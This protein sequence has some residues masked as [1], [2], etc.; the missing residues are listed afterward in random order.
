MAIDGAV[1]LDLPSWYTAPAR[2]DYVEITK[3]PYQ[4]Q[5]FFCLPVQAKVT[6]KLDVKEG[7]GADGATLNHQGIRP[8]R[9]TL[10]LRL[11]TKTDED[12][13]NAF[14]PVVNPKT[15]P[16]GRVLAVISYPTTDRAKIRDVYIY[17]ISE[18]LR[19]DGILEV[20]LECLEHL[21]KKTVPTTK[22]KKT[23]DIRRPNAFDKAKA[24]NSN[25]V[26]TSVPD[27]AKDTKI[28]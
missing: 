27:P 2:H 6:H 24:T 20:R 13:W 23:G 17:D 22:T 7:K 10:V 11:W 5:K 16:Q 1:K 14:Y 26:R 12:R 19:Q 25:D 18:E 4:P 3:V 15:N 28:K 9:V 21:P 8:S